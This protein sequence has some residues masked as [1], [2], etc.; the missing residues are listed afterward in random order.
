[1]V[2]D[3][4]DPELYFKVF[5]AVNR[6]TG[7]RVNILFLPSSPASTSFPSLSNFFLLP[8]T[9]AP[10]QTFFSPDEML[11]AVQRHHPVTSELF[12][13]LM[14]QVSCDYIATPTA[15]L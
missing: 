14:C 15:W 5:D 4:Y 12:K 11:R 10:L 7:E 13:V 1:M 2:Q 9:S 8:L 6:E 3:Q